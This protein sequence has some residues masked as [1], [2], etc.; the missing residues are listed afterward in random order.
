M[1]SSMS[2]AAY[3]RR[4]MRSTHAPRVDRP[5][6]AHAQALAVELEPVAQ[7]QGGIGQLVDGRRADAVGGEQARL[8]AGQPQLVTAQV[9]AVLAVEAERVVAVERKA[10]VVQRHAE[11]G[12]ALDDGRAGDVEQVAHA[13]AIWR[14]RSRTGF[15]RPIHSRHGGRGSPT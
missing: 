5:L 8:H 13:I 10:P 4:M 14:Q 11:P 1:S 7:G 2:P 3:E 6:D 15:M 12:R 9:T